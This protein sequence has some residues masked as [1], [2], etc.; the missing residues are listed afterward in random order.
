M[1]KQRNAFMLLILAAMLLLYG[2]GP[3]FMAT[4]TVSII[5]IPPTPT[6]SVGQQGQ[7]VTAGSQPAFA[8]LRETQKAMQSVTS[9]SFTLNNSTDTHIADTNKD[10]P[11][12]HIT[13]FPTLIE[14]DAVPPLARYL[15]GSPNPY[16]VAGKNEYFTISKNKE[17]VSLGEASDPFIV[18]GG[19]NNPQEYINFTLDTAK[20]AT[21]IGDEKVAGFDT[22]HLKFIL[23]TDSIGMHGNNSYARDIWIDKDTHY[24]RQIQMTE[25][26]Q[27]RRPW[28]DALVADPSEV[29]YTSGILLY[30]KHNAPLTPPIEAPL[31]STPVKP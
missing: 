26:F 13:P 24:L 20:C 16:L 21:I 1:D 4:N 29:S 28:E 31:A 9:Y 3:A 23:P 30:L 25:I 17:Y 14:G 2:C 12:A 5:A 11:I 27:P 7:K 6:A 10:A 8:L 22:I 15:D 19:L 18:T